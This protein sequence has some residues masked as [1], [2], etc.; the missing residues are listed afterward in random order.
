LQ[1]TTENCIIGKLNY[2]CSQYLIVHSVVTMDAD[3]EQPDQCLQH[4]CPS[5]LSSFYDEISPSVICLYI[6]RLFRVGGVYSCSV[7][8]SCIWRSQL[9]NLDSCFFL[10]RYQY[11]LIGRVTAY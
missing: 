8:E 5:Y 6:G 1:R 10:V 3:S 7:P 11:S 9:I 4:S 2:I